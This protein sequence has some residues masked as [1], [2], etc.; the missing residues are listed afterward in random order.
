[1]LP[2]ARV[3]LDTPVRHLDR[4]FDYEVAQADDRA[5]QPGS[6]VRV[7][8]AGRL[9]DGVIL[10]R[11]A[12]RTHD[13]PLTQVHA[14]PSSI[15]TFT[16]A[17]IGAIHETAAGFLGT[18]G[19]VA[20]SA[21]PPRQAR[22]EQDRRRPGPKTPVLPAPGLPDPVLPAP[23]LPGLVLPAPATDGRAPE[24]WPHLTAGP[25]LLR[26]IAAGEAVSA[27]LT[28]PPG[29]PWADVLAG[30]V[31]VASPGGA[32]IVAPSADDVDQC[33]D[34]LADLDRVCLTQA[35]G[36]AARYRAFLRCRDR[37]VSL[38]IGTRSAVFAPVGNLRLIVVVDDSDDLH[39]SPRAPYWTTLAVARA[40]ARASGCALVLASRARSVTA[41]WCVEYEGFG[42]VAAPRSIVRQRAPRIVFA[43]DPEAVARAGSAGRARIPPLAIQAAREGLSGGPVLVSV[44]RRGYRPHLACERCR[45]PARCL[46]GG[47]LS[48]AD[49]TSPPTCRV[50]QRAATHWRCARCGHPRLRGLVI[51]AGRTAE[52]LARAFPGQRVLLAERG[53]P[54]PELTAEQ[55]TGCLIVA[56]PG[57]EPVLAGGYAGALILDADI[58]LSLPLLEAPES[59]LRRWLAVAAMVTSGTVVIAG[60]HP[61]PEITALIRW[62][63]VTWARNA[64]SERIAAHLPPASLTIGVR[65]AAAD[66]ADV[67]SEVGS[68]AP[69]RTHGPMPSGAQ[70]LGYLVVDHRSRELVLPML[71][72]L[73]IAR[74]ARGQQPLN[75]RVDPPWL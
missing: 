19:D 24:P 47:S 21:A 45:A 65:G 46:C 5:A 30:L 71:R 44:P 49:A 3:R 27:A 75:V 11:S 51:G 2:I 70:A 12:I 37:E 57:A 54:I 14:V 68:A 38:V 16:P 31:R 72:A 36:P 4:D 15:P 67:L 73:L 32:V 8:F 43:G 69:V 39:T 60:R 52:E 33:S 13:G 40:R 61:S 25:A 17:V 35:L 18:F 41:Q 28:L 9:M 56:T 22:V 6:R 48:A 23:G 58:A 20:R 50:C 29:W 63:P 62:D 64:L 10:E 34:A 55:S 42:S 59:A 66:V 26:R 74:S 1:M 7:R 53:S